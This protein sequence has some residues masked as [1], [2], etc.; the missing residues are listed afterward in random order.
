[1]QKRHW[2]KIA[3]FQ[4]KY[5]V[6]TFHRSRFSNQYTK[7]VYGWR[8]WC[9]SCLL[10]KHICFACCD[11]LVNTLCLTFGWLFVIQVYHLSYVTC[12]ELLSRQRR[13]WIIDTFSIEEENPGPFPYELGKVMTHTVQKKIRATQ[14]TC[15]GHRGHEWGAHGKNSICILALFLYQN[16]SVNHKIP[17]FF[18]EIWGKKSE[19]M[20]E[21]WGLS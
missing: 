7:S 1:M 15:P 18:S 13:A 10:N 6:C 19:Q 16:S 11:S 21:I 3:L 14:T 4:C 9:Q 20:I 2:I 8:E 17:I 5:L 12:S